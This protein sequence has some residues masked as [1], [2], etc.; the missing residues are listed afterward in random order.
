MCNVVLEGERTKVSRS[1]WR[2]AD[3]G[4]SKMGE[5]FNPQ[6]KE[7]HWIQQDKLIQ[8]NAY[9]TFKN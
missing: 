7:A 6:M 8:N 5:N 1:I 3:R 2:A 4:F 9:H